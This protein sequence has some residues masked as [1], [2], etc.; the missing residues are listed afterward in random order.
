LNTK[1]YL[2]E[3]KL[4]VSSGQLTRPSCCGGSK[5]KGLLRSGQ[6]ALPDR[7]NSP[8]AKLP[9][10]GRTVSLERCQVMQTLTGPPADSPNPQTADTES[11]NRI[12]RRED[13]PPMRTADCPT[14]P[15]AEC[16]L[17]CVLEV[18]HPPSKPRV[19]G[20]Q[21]RPR[22]SEKRRFQAG[23]VGRERIANPLFAGSNPAS[24]FHVSHA[25]R[26]A[27][28]VLQRRRTGAERGGCVL[29][30]SRTGPCFRRLWHALTNG[31]RGAGLW[32]ARVA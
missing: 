27:C 8:E 31:T 24:A 6:A 23:N 3:S 11:P 15:H 32:R 16:V 12:Y 4:R 5:G 28:G 25:Q 22:R 2:N 21:V 14:A 7:M 1:L 13:T 10:C 18:A 30:V 9:M 19:R 29:R 17:N 20:A 26:V